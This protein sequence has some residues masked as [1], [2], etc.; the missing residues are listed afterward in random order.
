MKKIVIL[1]ISLLILITAL[2][3]YIQPALEETAKKEINHFMQL[4]INHVSFIHK[5]DDQQLLKIQYNN[6]KITSFGFNMI[7]LNRETSEYVNQLEETLL[8]IEEGQYHND[9][10]SVYNK[11][12]KKVSDNQGVIASLP[13]GSL[14]NNVFLQHIGPHIHIKYKTLSIVSSQIHKSVKNYGINHILVTIDLTVLVQL[15]IIVPLNREDYKKEFQIPLVFEIIEG[16]VPSWYQ[17]LS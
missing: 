3:F 5:I 4:V 12:L 8:D 15:Q 1:F 11:R 7:Y 16:E 6:D 2:S 14:T 13:L 9:S 17:G 10:H